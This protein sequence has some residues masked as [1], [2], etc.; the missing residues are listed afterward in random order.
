MLF[1]IIKNH[2]GSF[3]FTFTLILL[4]AAASLLFPL[5][6]G[7]AVD[8]ALSGDYTGAIQLGVLGLCALGAG[9]GRRF[10]DTRFYAK[11]YEEQ[12]DKILKLQAEESTSVKT[13][14]L[15]M[16]REVIA[17]MEHSFPALTN[18][19]IGFVGVIIIIATLSFQVFIGTLIA[20]VLIMVIY[21]LTGKRTTRYNKGYND[22]LE[23]QVS[24][25]ESNEPDQ[26]RGHIKRLMRWSIRLSDLETVNFS[27]SWIFLMAFL[28]V[29]IV[30]SAG[31]STI[32]TGGLFAL[33]MYVFQYIESLMSLPYFYQQWLR[34]R[35][36]G[37]RFKEFE[38]CTDSTLS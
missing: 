3:A 1:P 33:V 6:I 2:R 14:R 8:D 12:G 32:Q 30:V 38:H 15:N 19:T 16:L 35:E 26:T 36:I 34:L 18:S 21:L 4:E 20:S 9:A 11:V 22:E 10:F 31:D 17:F 37:E 28:V 13:A 7:M 24:A 5:F 29:S 25:I 23:T 27:V